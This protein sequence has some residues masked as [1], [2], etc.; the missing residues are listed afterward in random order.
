[1]G[2]SVHSCSLCGFYF[3]SCFKKQPA[4]S[5]NAEFKKKWG[6]GERNQAFL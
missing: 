5:E 6:G 3:V 2:L 4:I 1:M